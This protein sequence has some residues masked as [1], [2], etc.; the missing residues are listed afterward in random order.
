[1]CSNVGDELN[2]TCN[3]RVLPTGAFNAIPQSIIIERDDG[4]KMMFSPLDGAIITQ[5]KWVFIIHLYCPH[6]FFGQV[7][8]PLLLQNLVAHLDYKL[9]KSICG[10][11]KKLGVT[12][13]SWAILNSL[14][15]IFGKLIIIASLY[16]WLSTKNYIN[17]LIPFKNKKIT[18]LI[19]LIIQIKE[20]QENDVMP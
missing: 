5:L 12:L 3:M 10:H 4:V 17:K 1:M 8:L 19:S 6:A 9:W 14:L 20:N 11:I 16:I 15:I 7:K 18:D 2:F 13:S